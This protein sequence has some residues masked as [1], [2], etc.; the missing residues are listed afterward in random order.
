M[1][2]QK[3]SSWRRRRWNDYE[4]RVSTF[5]DGRGRRMAKEEENEANVTKGGTPL[6]LIVGTEC[7][8]ITCYIS[9]YDTKG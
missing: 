9:D 7:T 8:A 3:S 4:A 6:S 2:I 1:K 5:F